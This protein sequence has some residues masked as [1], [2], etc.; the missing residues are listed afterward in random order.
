MCAQCIYRK[1]QDEANHDSY[2]CNL[3]VFKCSRFTAERNLCADT[4]CIDNV[5]YTSIRNGK[6]LSYFFYGS[7]SPLI[8]GGGTVVSLAFPNTR[9]YSMH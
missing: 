6:L 9:I 1:K 5:G 7:W 4:N 2:I 8:G 3:V